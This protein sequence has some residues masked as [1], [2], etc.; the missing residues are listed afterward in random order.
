MKI[1]QCLAIA[2]MTAG[3]TVAAHAG[4]VSRGEELSGSCAACHGADGNSTNPEWPKIAGQ[5]ARYTYEQL[6]HFQSGERDDPLMAGEVA[7]LSDQDMKDLAAYYAAQ[8]PEIGSA[9]PDLVD[10]GRDIYRGGIPDKGVAACIACHGG[11]GEGLAAAGFPAL[12]GQHA[13][14]TARQLEKYRSGERATDP[15]RMM[16]GVAERMSDDEIRAVSSY[17]EGLYRQR[18]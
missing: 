18:D 9:D 3:L 12:Y 7:D 4:D 1:W 8:E 17:I 15:N 6:R 2:A 10:L 14:Y 11:A 13:T 16:R 5:H